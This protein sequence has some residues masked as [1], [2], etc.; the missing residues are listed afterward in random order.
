MPP[1]LNVRDMTLHALW[2]A[3]GQGRIKSTSMSRVMAVKPRADSVAHGLVQ[4]HSN[5]SAMQLALVHTLPTPQKVGLRSSGSCIFHGTFDARDWP[6][7]DVK[8]NQ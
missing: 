5:H 7:L 2:L 8:L 1:A 4:Q 6:V 3:G